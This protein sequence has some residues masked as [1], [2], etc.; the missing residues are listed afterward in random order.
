MSFGPELNQS[1]RLY[2]LTE[3][4]TAA[5]PYNLLIGPLTSVIPAW[6]VQKI[7]LFGIL[8]LAGLGAYRLFPYKGAG[9]YYAGIL[10][11]MNPFT[12]V[13]F[14]SGQW[15]IL[16]SYAIT[17]FA[18]KAFLDLIEHRTM[19]NVVLVVLLSTLVGLLQVHSF[20]ILFLAYI[21]ILIVKLV[22]ERKDKANLI[23]VS[24]YTVVTAVFFIVLNIYWI[25]PVLFGGASTVDQIG[26]QD[27]PAFAPRGSSG[28]GVMFDVASMHGFWRGGHLHS[29]DILSTWWLP[30][31]FILFLAVYGFFSKVESKTVQ[32]LRISLGIIGLVSL[33]LAIGGSN[34]ITSPVFTWLSDHIFFFSGFRDSHKFVALLCLCY[35]YLGGLGVSQI[36]SNFSN[37]KTRLRRC[38]I[39]AGILLALVLPMLYSANMFGFNGLLG[40][41]YFPQQWHEINDH[42]NEDRDDFN[43][44]FLPW[45][46]YMDFTWLPNADKRLGNP[47]PLFFDKPIAC[48][49]NIEYAGIYSQSTNDSSKYVEFL[50]ANAGNISNMGELLSPLNIKYVILVNEADYASYEFLYQQED[51]HIEIQ[52]PDIVLFGNDHSTARLYAV[53][54]AVSISRWEDILELSK[55]QDIMKHVY[56]LGNE[57]AEHESNEWEKLNYSKECPVKYNVE[58][59]ELKYTVFTLPQRVN[60]EHWE[61]SGE[62]PSAWNL[63][64]MP[65][66]SSGSEGADIVYSRFFRVYLPSYIIS[67]I[68]LLVIITIYVLR[69]IKER[70][71]SIK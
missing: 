48:G 58:G 22:R 65:A 14:M 53:E 44:L 59:S 41:T 67:G 7:L 20:F 30:F 24:K 26:Q 36:A 42:L 32:W 64:L 19:K 13:R 35:A 29:N 33:G 63:G 5:A 39:L 51:L 4:V 25:V 71:H 46:Q 38:G 23:H 43:V 10:Y 17:P 66:F 37:Q 60:N 31:L 47:A 62:A 6:V 55:S 45:H 61:M 9:T 1:N 12:Y 27:I 57:S 70:K 54:S 8:L 3:G 15:T 68:A 69:S 18:I 52:Y 40:T 34:E 50:L 11:M 28:L 56:V 49:D 16:A 2:G 21:V